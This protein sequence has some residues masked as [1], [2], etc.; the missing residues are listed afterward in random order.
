MRVSSSGRA[1]AARS[2]DHEIGPDFEPREGVYSVRDMGCDQWEHALSVGL[3]PRH[4]R[5]LSDLIHDM[6]DRLEQRTR[7]DAWRCTMKR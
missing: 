4:D 5:R 1:S 2:D 6:V 7:R 3:F